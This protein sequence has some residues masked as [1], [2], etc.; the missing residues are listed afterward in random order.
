MTDTTSHEIMRVIDASL[1][2]V[3][4]G[5]RVLEEIAR[6]VLND[7]ILTQQ[8]K[9][10]RH[11]LTVADAAQNQ[12]L[13]EAR[14]A[15]N[16]IGADM[17]VPGEGQEKELRNILVAN[18]RRVQ[19]SLRTLE[20]LAKVPGK[21]VGL[22]T[23]KFRQARFRLYTIE[24]KLLSRL[25]RQEKVKLVSG[26]YVIIDTQALRGREP[27]EITRQV[28]R[29]GARVIQLRDKT[30]GK[31]ELLGV[32]RR[33]KDLCAEY[34]ILF[35]I[36]D[37]LDLA[38]AIG[39]DGLHLGQEDLPFDVARKPMPIDM[40]LGCT[41][42]TVA[43]ALAAWSEGADYIAVGSIYPTLSK[44]HVEV[45]GLKRLRHIKQAVP[46]PLIAIGGITRDNAL[47]VIR[48]GADSIC[49]ISAV[50]GPEPPEEATRQM[51]NMFRGKDQ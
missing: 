9:T 5:L 20:E 47:E 21:S 44:E 33:M 48:A 13:L 36:N 11:E 41:T 24:R 4:E 14:D 45:V 23:D 37:H 1:N 16:D 38:L 34:N 35:I 19:E 32:A 46:L 42:T 18:A 25:L 26:L 29:G 12:Q 3:S 40:L 31:K 28:I 49:V 51:A 17:V 8:L 39:A 10:I 27:V 7:E 30:L 22:D 6:L 43:Q 2:R 15:E 50:L